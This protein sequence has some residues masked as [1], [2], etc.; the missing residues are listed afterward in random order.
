[1]RPSIRLGLAEGHFVE[2]QPAQEYLTE[3]GSGN[4]EAHGL[5]RLT[6]TERGRSASLTRRC[7]AA[8][9]Q[10]ERVTARAGW[11]EAGSVPPSAC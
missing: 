9:F 3:E 4:F 8:L 1:M 5:P 10:R 2:S 7:R 11:A 6:L